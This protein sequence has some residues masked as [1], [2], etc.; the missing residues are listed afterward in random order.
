MRS[1]R[2][3]AALELFLTGPQLI[4]SWSLSLHQVARG[5]SSQLPSATQRGSPV[6]NRQPAPQGGSRAR[7]EC[8]GSDP[9]LPS[10]GGHSSVSGENCALSRPPAKVPQG[11][12]EPRRTK[13]KSRQA[14]PGRRVE[15]QITW[16]R[17][18]KPV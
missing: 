6:L 17:D 12:G 5:A 18:G 11:P 9:M 13:A 8:S 14:A 4:Q 16:A 2:L 1:G 10:E 3:E 7:E 15:L